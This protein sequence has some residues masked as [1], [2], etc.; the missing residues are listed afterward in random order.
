M[1]GLFF[2]T[3]AGHCE[4][5]FVGDVP[6]HTDIEHHALRLDLPSRE[7]PFPAGADGPEPRSSPRKDDNSAGGSGA[8][9]AQHVRRLPRGGVPNI[10]ARNDPLAGGQGGEHH[11]AA[12]WPQPVRHCIRRSLQ[13]SALELATAC[14]PIRVN[15][16]APADV[17]MGASLLRRL[18]KLRDAHD[19]AARGT[20]AA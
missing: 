10:A 14:R 7:F 13:P 17:A 16:A 8:Q 2:S 18:R 5:D 4:S 9:E 6:G 3:E 12:I 19:A 11:T 20:G 1:P 15:L